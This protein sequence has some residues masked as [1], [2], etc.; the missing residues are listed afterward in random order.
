MAGDTSHGSKPWKRKCR[1]RARGGQVP[2]LQL[3]AQGRWKTLSASGA[4]A[5]DT[6]PEP[7]GASIL[8]SVTAENPTE[9]SAPSI[10]L[11]QPPHFL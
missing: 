4:S 2:S 6:P 7:P 5:R 10:H 3:A 11:N 1:V 8:C 9:G